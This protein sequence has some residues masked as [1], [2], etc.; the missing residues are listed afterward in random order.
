M[1][2]WDSD[3]IFAIAFSLIPLIPGAMAFRAFMRLYRESDEMQR[4]M[5][6]EGVVT[7]AALATI[8]WGAIQLPEHIW[9]P[10]VKAD[11]V[12]AVLFLG[13]SAGMIRARLRRV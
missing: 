2:G 4:E 8:F 1:S 7:G 13:F 5:L 12:M 10:K 6:T 3:S 11:L 9:L